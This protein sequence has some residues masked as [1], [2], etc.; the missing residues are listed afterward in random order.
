MI[1]LGYIAKLYEFNQI[2]NNFY[3]DIYLAGQTKITHIKI[4]A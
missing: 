1:S 3:T 2:K 4:N